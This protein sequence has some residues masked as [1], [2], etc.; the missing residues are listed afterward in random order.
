[1]EG[2]A[3]RKNARIE[4][5]FGFIYGSMESALSTSY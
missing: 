2:N 3:K 4:P 1:M 5:P